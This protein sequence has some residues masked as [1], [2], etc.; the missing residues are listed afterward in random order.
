MPRG[1]PADLSSGI[2]HCPSCKID[3]P[4]SA[5][6]KCKSQHSGY[7]AYCRQCMYER[8]KKYAAKPENKTRF[9]K[10]LK[11]ARKKNPDLFRDYSLRSNR[12]LALGTYKKM[13]DAQEGK[14]A[15]CKTEKLQAGKFRLHVDHCHETKLIRG[16]L[17]HNCNVGIGNL[18]H[19]EKIMLA[20]I[21]YLRKF[22]IN[23][24]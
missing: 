22:P 10:R 14:C 5:F 16:L 3:F 21:Q 23:Q 4:L 7:Q 1:I 20:A 12:G 6:S 9:N 18:R 17:C 8:F 24:T 15:I 13:H 11:I 2:K 19:S